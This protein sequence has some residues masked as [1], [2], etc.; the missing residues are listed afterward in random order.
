MCVALLGRFV[1]DEIV[2]VSLLALTAGFLLVIVGGSTSAML[3]NGIINVGTCVFGVALNSTLVALA[4]RNHLASMSIVGWGQGLSGLAT[5]L[6]AL[7]GT[8]ANALDA[9][10]CHR[11]LEALVAGLVLALVAYVLFG[12]RGFSLKAT[13]E[14]VVPPEPA[15]EPQPLTPSAEES[16]AARCHELA[17]AH[18]LTPREEETFSMLARGRDRAY[19][20]ERLGVSRNTV[21][22]H[23]K[24]VYAKLGIHSHQELIDLVEE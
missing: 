20:E 1:G 9:A 3:A 14:G 15:C 7:L 2:N 21:K 24:H 4:A 8:T 18:G 6:G 19:I 12:L 5:T 22:A 10:G 11:Q 23:V 13:I 16:F 17:C